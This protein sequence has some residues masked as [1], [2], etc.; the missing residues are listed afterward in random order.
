MPTKVKFK[1]KGFNLSEDSNPGV[2]VFDTKS[3]S[4]YVGGDRFSRPETITQSKKYTSDQTY[5]DTGMFSYFGSNDYINKITNTNNSYTLVEFDSTAVAITGTEIEIPINF[6]SKNNNSFGNEYIHYFLLKNISSSDLTITLVPPTIQSVCII[7]D[8]TPIT[9]HANNSIEISTKVMNDNWIISKSIEMPITQKPKNVIYYTTS[10][11]NVVKLIT[12]HAS[13]VFGAN[14]VSNVYENGVGIITFDGDVTSIGYN[15]FSNYHEEPQDVEG[16]ETSTIEEDFDTGNMTSI[17]IPDSV[18]SIEECAFS[19]CTSLTSVTIPNSVTSIGNEAFQYCSSL[20]SINI[21]DS[22]TNMAYGVFYECTNLTSVTIGNSVTRI[23]Y[24]V[25][26]GCTNLTSIVVSTGNTVYDS[27]NNC[28]A[29]IETS[30]N[31]LII[32]CKNT[33]I[34][35]SVTSI[36]GYAFRECSGLTSINI[37]DSVTSIGSYAFQVCTGLTSVTIGNSVTSIGECAFDSCISLTSINIPDS[38]TSIGEMAFS[39]CES[40]TSVTIGN[41]MT[42]SIDFQGCINLTSIVVST[43]NSVYDSRNNCNAI[44]ETSTNKLIIGCKNTIIPNSVTSIGERAF[45]ECSGLTSI[46]IPNSVTSI[47]RSAFSSC[48]GL[49]SVTIPDS[50]TSIE[51]YAFWNCRDLTSITSLNTTPPTIK[52]DTLPS[53]RTYTIYVPAGSVNAYKGASIWSS[54]KTQIQAI[55]Q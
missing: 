38:V 26:V 9:L 3:K 30:T 12:S 4:I 41:S 25:F 21:P 40:L 14:I 48:T 20:T 10:D 33:I 15:A 1:R 35:N 16:G 55:Q 29:I 54:R 22:V 24:D 31:K 28:N 18:T 51:N 49:T 5:Y 42:T 37:P 17:T 8:L 50:V 44:I 19:Y 46:N 11:G 32:G 45:Q 6:P 36:E 34:P 39:Y 53:H 2:I 43:G 47:G 52:S 7:G 23:E 27:R 13:D